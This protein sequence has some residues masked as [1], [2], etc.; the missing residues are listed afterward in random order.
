MFL[1]LDCV[2]FPT[3]SACV[4]FHYLI[5]P[6]NGEY[7]VVG[8]YNDKAIDYHHYHCPALQNASHSSTLDITTLVYASIEPSN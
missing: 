8:V 3:S 7:T 6:A 5:S 1:C 4:F 2:P